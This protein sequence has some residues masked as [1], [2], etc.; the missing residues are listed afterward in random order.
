M[1][2]IKGTV[3]VRPA[4][5]RMW[6]VDAD[7]QAVCWTAAERR[8]SAQEVADALNAREETALLRRTLATARDA[9]GD[10]LDLYGKG[11]QVYGWHENDA[12]EPLDAFFD[13]NG[14][15]DAMDEI[16]A[17]YAAHPE[18]EVRS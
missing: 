15:G 5:Y 8:E 6:I 9:F 3:K 12:L 16:R 18:R 13:E 17:Y 1:G 4:P 2:E 14:A 7:G 10:L 11:L